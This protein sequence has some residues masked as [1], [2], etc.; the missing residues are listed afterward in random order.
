MRGL[1]ALLVVNQEV[2][3]HSH[4]SLAILGYIFMAC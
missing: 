3:Y 4:S 1:A 2:S